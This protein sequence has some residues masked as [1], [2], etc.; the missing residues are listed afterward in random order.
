MGPRRGAARLHPFRSQRWIVFT[1]APTTDS[2][3]ASCGQSEVQAV[4]QQFPY[5][6]EGLNVV[7]FSRERKKKKKSFQVHISPV[8]LQGNKLFKY[9]NSVHAAKLETPRFV[10]VPQEISG[11]ILYSQARTLVTTLSL[12]AWIK[13]LHIISREICVP[14]SQHFS[15][16]TG[17]PPV[18]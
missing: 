11:N 8:G 2:A 16:A 7:Y 1:C 3:L 4:I 14:N 13:L 9:Y 15:K 10:Q 18:T 5:T 6:R 12:P 17:N